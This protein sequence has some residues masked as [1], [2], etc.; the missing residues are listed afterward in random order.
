M[1]CARFKY[2]KIQFLTSLAKCNEESETPLAIAIKT[3]HF[4]VIEELL[5]VFRNSDLRI[6]KG[7]PMPVINQLPLHVAMEELLEYL[8][9]RTYSRC[10][11]IFILGVFIESPAFTRQDTIIAFELIGAS[12]ICSGRFFYTIPAL[13]CWRR[14][15]VLC[16]VPAVGA[17]HLPKTPAVCDVSA[18]SSNVVF[19]SSVEVMTIEELNLLEERMYFNSVELFIQALLVIRRILIQNNPG[20]PYWGISQQFDDVCRRV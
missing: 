4:P 7:L 17:E 8:L 1:K 3:K 18:A 6:N 9:E 13:N 2:N 14:A 16:F 20:H 5:E 10:W 12:K 15:M 11:M 19:G